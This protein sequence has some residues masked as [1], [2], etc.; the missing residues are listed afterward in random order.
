MNEVL[1]GIAPLIGKS[2]RMALSPKNASSTFNPHRRNEPEPTKSIKQGQY[3]RS[4]P[5]A[6]GIIQR[7]F[8]GRLESVGRPYLPMASCRNLGQ[9]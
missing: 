8:P 4:V 2:A 6:H 5:F 9:C 7:Y 3:I 1:Y